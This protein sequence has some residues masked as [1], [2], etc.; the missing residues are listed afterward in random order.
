MTLDDFD[1]PQLTPLDEEIDAIRMEQRELRRAVYR[2]ENGV[3]PKI[4]IHRERIEDAIKSAKK[5]KKDYGLSYRELKEL[6]GDHIEITAFHNILA[7]GGSISPLTIKDGTITDFTSYFGSEEIDEFPELA[8]EMIYLNRARLTYQGNPWTESSNLLSSSLCVSD[9]MENVRY[10]VDGV[11]RETVE[12][13]REAIN[14]LRD[15]TQRELDLD[16]PKE[17]EESIAFWHDSYKHT[18]MF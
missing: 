2:E 16:S 13:M 9:A 5:R 18:T 14:E 3:G 17:S 1:D 6:M 8:R 11:F 4:R 7:E 12:R 10:G 15:L